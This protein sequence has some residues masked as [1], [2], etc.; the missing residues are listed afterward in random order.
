MISTQ[1]FTGPEIPLPIIDVEIDEDQERLYEMMFNTVMGDAEIAQGVSFI[2]DVEVELPVDGLKPS[3]TREAYAQRIS[4]CGTWMSRSFRPQTGAFAAS[5]SFCYRWRE[6]FGLWCER[7]LTD[8][9]VRVK[10]KIMAAYRGARAL[11]YVR[12]N[13]NEA[14]QVLKGIGRD[15]YQRYPFQELDD[16]GNIVLVDF[17]VADKQYIGHIPTAKPL[18]REEVDYV[19]YR[20]LASTPEEYRTSGT[21][22]VPKAKKS[23]RSIVQA[24]NIVVDHSR[25]SKDAEKTALFRTY[26]FT[27]SMNPQTLDEVED[28]LDR[29][30]SIFVRELKKA[31]GYLLPNTGISHRPVSCDLKCILWKL[32]I[33]DKE[34]LK[35]EVSSAIDTIPRRTGS[36]M[37]FSGTDPD[38]PLIH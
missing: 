3:E 22:G 6:R 25:T 8:R 23:T 11:H 38:P 5:P 31:G 10:K 16:G 26:S 27:A 17:I 29:R 20:A 37:A 34:Q 1:L 14:K 7:C 35:A 28:C 21:L 24:P 12:L 9:M 2:G 4:E 18:T 19:N 32:Y 13:H 33:H 15:Q 30:M 36:Q